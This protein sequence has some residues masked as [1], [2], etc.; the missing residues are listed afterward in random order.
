MRA[1]RCLFCP[2]RFTS[3]SAPAAKAITRTGCSRRCALNLA[4]TWRNR[5]AKRRLE[6][7]TMN[8]TRSDA[9]VFFGATGDLAYKKIFPALQALVKHGRLNVPVIGVAKSDWNRD[10]LLARAKDSVVKNGGIDL[11]AFEKLSTLLRYVGGDY[12]DPATFEAIRKEL[13]SAQRP[14]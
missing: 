13:G 8:N 6:E 7:A 10:Q 5:P 4:V 11:P 9:L 2:A 3:A 1:C 14:A 12:Q